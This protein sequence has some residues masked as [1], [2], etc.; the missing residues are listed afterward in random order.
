M[1]KRDGRPC[2]SPSTISDT[3]AY[4]TGKRK[5][6]SNERIISP[7]HMVDLTSDDEVVIQDTVKDPF[8]GFS[9]DL[10]DHSLLGIVSAFVY[11]VEF[12]KRGLP[13]AHICLFMHVDHKLHSVDHIDK[14]I[15]AKIPDK[16]EDPHVYSLVKLLLLL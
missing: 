6:L 16:N 9:K 7:V 3:V 12:Q 14:Y 8:A 1:S 2:S 4:S 11:T 10:K 15:S 13:H 5:L